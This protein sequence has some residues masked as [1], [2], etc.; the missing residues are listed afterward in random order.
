MKIAFIS[1]ILDY[2]WGGADALWTCAAEA[3]LGRGDRVLIATSEKAS[4]HDR[5][6]ALVARGAELVVRPAPDG[7]RPIWQRA[8][9]KR[10]GG[11]RGLHALS[12]RVRSF[13]PDLLVFSCGGTYDP[14]N[15]A[16]LTDWLRATGTPFRI[17]A[18]FQNE[19]PALSEENRLRAKQ[20]LEAAER[21]F[22]VSPRN[23][24]IT[25]LHLLSPLANAEC[26]H[27]CMVHNPLPTDSNLAWAEPPPWSFACV[28][29]LEPVKGVD[30]LVQALAE[31]LGDQP[32]W[33]L[34]LYGR[35]PQHD[36]LEA[37]ARYCGIGDRVS[38]RGF[39]PDLDDVW[40][41]NH[42]LV[43]SAIDEGVPMTIPE[44]MLRGR[45]VLATRVGGATEWIEHGRTGYLCPAPTTGLLA[46]SL[47]EAWGQRE[48][49]REMGQAAAARTRSLYRPDD[50]KRIVA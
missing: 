26:M 48:R 9:R 33:R 45:A 17:I 30:L 37:C 50:Y 3:A 4:R 10:P 27:G 7:P 19:H 8:W 24:E 29:R 25:R 46:A 39:V 11:S 5:V 35:G 16:P 18:N 2:P 28:A 15:E 36:Y 32:G 38:L 22:C 14:I 12:D 40:R 21:I 47:R 43:S 1:T 31:G 41:Q 34:N 23:L 13:A 6:G 49:W 42:L 20:L 44:A